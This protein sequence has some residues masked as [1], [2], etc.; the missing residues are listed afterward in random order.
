MR[1]G[2]LVPALGMCLLAGWLV[3]QSQPPRQT[4]GPTPDGGFLLNSG[5]K[6]TP[7]GKQVPLDTFPMSSI[8]SKDGRFLLVLNQGF[9]PPSISIL[10]TD[11]YQETNRVPVKDGWLGLAMSPD[12][13][14]VYV[15]GGS[16]GAV[17][18]FAYQDGNLTP[19][20]T[21]QIVP[22]QSVTTS[23][24]IGDVAIS[25]DGRFLYAA[26]LYHDAIH[27]V[28]LSTARVT[29]KLATGRRPYRILFHPDGKSYFVSSWVDGTVTQHNSETGERL[30]FIRL[31]QHPTDMVIRARK[32]AENSEQQQAFTY[33]LFVAAANTNNV[34]VVGIDSGRDMR[35]AEN[36]NISMT[37]RQP[38]GMTPSAV[39]MNADQS[40]LFVVCS[41]ANAAAVVDISEDT[42]AVLGFIPT[43]WYP[44]AVRSMPDKR[45]LIFNGRGLRSFPNATDPPNPTKG[46]TPSHLGGQA[47][48]LRRTPPDGHNVR[49]RSMDRRAV[50]QVVANRA[51]QFAVS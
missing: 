41:D 51:R 13:K 5:W 25:P 50:R 40:R 9:K 49:H 48:G 24:F 8:L 36:I 11:T 3:S 46:P 43:A 6:I 14:A 38:F 27:L 2:A 22:A 21:I 30:N 7:A 33:R 26:G 19:G 28:N 4:V 12:G 44:T 45:L 16:T 31:G 15:G 34:Y 29:E 32:P 18:E 37:A 10:R 39:A 35:L 23:D 20:R 47:A 42:S 1:I 17:F